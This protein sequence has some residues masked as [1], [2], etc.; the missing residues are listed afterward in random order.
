MSSTSEP[1]AQ[2]GNSSASSAPSAVRPY[3]WSVRRELWEHRS[4]FIA[5]LVAAGII[6]LG[7]LLGSMR[8]AHSLNDLPSFDPGRDGGILAA[9]FGFAALPVLSTSLIVAVFYCLSA[10]NGERRDRS[11]LFWKSLPVSDLISVA[12]KVA[13]PMVILPAVTLAIILA[14]HAIMLGLGTLVLVA[15]GL[16]PWP[17]W[18]DLPWF[19]LELT[20]GYLLVALSLWYAPIYAWL[21]MVSAWAKRAPFL[22]A[23][24]PPLALSLLEAIALGTS[25]VW[26]MLSY[27]MHGGFTEAFAGDAEHALRRLPGSH[28]M[29][30]D[31][32]RIDLVGFLETPGLWAGLV[33]ALA[34][35]AV[36]VWL[37]RYRDPI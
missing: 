13:V 21:L 31:L 8:L 33:F 37:R 15:H 24:L 35:L 20:V 32:P 1:L 34:F 25:N 19:R 7:L 16:N 18:T 30:G 23:V 6:V 22:W 26:R 9:P 10:L 36:A 3:Y 5:P 27:R 14:L 17:F 29:H 2:T 4:I 12:A 28:S 11:I